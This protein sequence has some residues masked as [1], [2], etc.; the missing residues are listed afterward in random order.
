MNYTLLQ[1]WPTPCCRDE[2]HPAA[3]MNYTLLQR[4]TTHTAEMNY[5]M[6]QRWTTQYCRDEDGLICTAKSKMSSMYTAQSDNLTLTG[7]CDLLAL[8]VMPWKPA[9]HWHLPDDEH[10]PCPLQVAID[11]PWRIEPGQLQAPL[12]LSHIA[13]VSH[14][15]VFAHPAPYLPAEQA[16][17]KF[18]RWG[19][20]Q[21]LE[22]EL[23][24]RG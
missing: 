14:A 5:T 6:L 13:L 17:H 11:V 9:L 24:L 21:F 2:L 18:K 22:E 3:K 7:K 1:K 8:Q 4:W 20:L 23:Q 10:V 19:H 12:T 15:Q 16:E